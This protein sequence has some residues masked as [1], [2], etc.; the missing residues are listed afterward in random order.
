AKV[1]ARHLPELK[2]SLPL[3]LGLLVLFISLSV[4]VI[5]LVIQTTKPPSESPQLA[6]TPTLTPT[7]TLLPTITLSPTIQPTAT[8]LP[9][10]EYKVVEGDVCSSIAAIFGVSVQ[11]IITQNNLNAAC[12]IVPG[13]TLLVPQPT[14]TA[15]PQPSATLDALQSTD[16]ACQKL[17]YQVLGTDTLSTIAQTYNVS[18]ASIREYNNMP[19]DIVYE[20]MY[21]SI[22]LCERKPTAGPTPTPTTPP[23]YPAPNLLLP[24]D[25][26]PFSI[27]QDAITVQWAAIGELRAGELY[28]VTIEDITSAEQKRMVEYVN[29]TKFIIPVSF[30]PTDKVPHI[31][32]WWVSVVRQINSGTNGSPIYEQAGLNSEKRVFTWTAINFDL[33]NSP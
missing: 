9:P 27:E 13:T 4:V 18:M 26:A 10:L 19:N 16:A 7:E 6:S 25:G 31:I 32:R 20:G 21:L 15:S 33:I 14:P 8:P 17:Q 29:D 2:L 12:D 11:S 23:P 30:R 3:A 28:S 1:S 22:P 24:L 5:F